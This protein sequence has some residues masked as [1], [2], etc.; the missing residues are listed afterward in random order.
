MRVYIKQRGRKYFIY[1]EDDN[2]PILTGYWA[3]NRKAGLHAVF[4]DSSEK[5]QLR[6][7]VGKCPWIGG[8]TSYLIKTTELPSEIEVEL[9]SRWKFDFQFSLDGDK[10]SY[11]GHNGHMKSL[12]KNDIQVAKF[13]KATFNWGERDS[14]Y[15]IYNSDEN[16]KLLLGLWIMRDMGEINDAEISIDLGNITSSAKVWNNNWFPTK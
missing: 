2:P 12:Y 16:V 14:G 6:V 5:E 7:S 3:S 8:P 15:I 4:F 13:N 11:Y 1:Q 9:K 10:Y